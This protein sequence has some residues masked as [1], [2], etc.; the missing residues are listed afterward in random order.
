MSAKAL[1]SDRYVGRFAPSPTGQLHIGSIITAMASY[2]DARSH[3]GTWLIRIED[4]DE[5]RRMPDAV[6]AIISVLNR[7]GMESDEKVVTQS[8]RKD[9]YESAIQQLE[10]SCYFCSCSRRE[11][12]DSALRA[13]A[14]GALVYPGTCRLKCGMEKSSKAVRLRISN[15][16]TVNNTIVFEDRWQGTVT[17]HLPSEAGDFIL[18]RAD[19]FFAYQFAVVVDDADQHVS[20]VVR[21]ADLLHST[22]RQIYL[23]RLLG[24]VTPS[25][26]HV[27]VAQNGQGEKFSKQTGAIPINSDNPL[28]VLISAAGFLNLSIERTSSASAFWH[29]AITQWKELIEQKKNVVLAQEIGKPWHLE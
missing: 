28:D 9:L 10:S 19:G 12:A 17:Q 1:T 7:Y 4:I 16:D 27:P 20:H 13:G 24:Y 25:Y 21:G 2:L 22:A 6:Q 26:L 8:E 11:I 23:Q 29:S 14:D 15:S 18:K 3:N 5:T